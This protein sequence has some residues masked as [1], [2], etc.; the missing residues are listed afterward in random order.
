MKDVKTN[1]GR[2]L[3]LRGGVS[4]LA[5][6]L[7]GAHG[8]QAQT[9]AEPKAEEAPVLEEIVVVGVR[10]ALESAL[11]IKRNAGTVVDSITATDIGAFPDKSVSEALQRVPGITVSRLQSSDD[12]THPS[13]EGTSVLIRGLTQ[14]RTEF[15]GRD[16]F[17]ADSYRGLN[18]NDVSPELMA[19]VDSYK[20]Q[21]ADMIEGGIAG[22]V[23]LR[24]RLPF[25]SDGLAIAGNIKGSYGDRSKKWTGEYS[26]MISNVWETNAGKF[27]LLANL[28][29][30]HVVT[31]TESV[32]MDKIDTYC[33]AGAVDA[34]GKAI[35]GADGAVGCTRNPFGGTGWAYMPDGIR[36]SL[37][38]YDRTRRGTSLAGQYE[39]DDGSFQATVQYN[40]SKYHNAWLENAS[41]VI[42][43]GNAYGSS[44]FRVRDTSV[45]GPATGSPALK[46]GADGMLESGLL[47]QGHGSWRGS[48][49]SLQDAI[50]TGSAVPGKPFVN[51]CG[52]GAC[53]STTLQDGLYFQN[54]ARN[55]DHREGTKDLS[56]NVKW[57]V[58]DRLHTSFDVQR[59]TA[60]TTNDDILVATG[61]M[62]D[63]QYSVG[64]NGVPNVVMKPGSN[65]NYAPGGLSN[66]H[67]YWIPFIQA[68]LEDNDAK[69]TAFRGDA[70]YDLDAA[71]GW[72][73]SLKVGVRHADRKQTVRYSTF[74]W[75]PVAASWN[76]NGPGF[77]ADSTGGAYPAGCGNGQPF[78]GY[79]A[80]IWDSVNLGDDFFN[81]DVYPNG[82]LVYLSR[83]VLKDRDRLVKSLSGPNTNNPV[84]PGWV[85]ICDRPG[86]PSGSCFLPS[87]VMHVQEKTNA[88]Y[89]MLR[90]GGGDMTIFN[91]ITVDGNVG[92][93]IVETKINSQ[94]SVGFPTDT[95]LRSLQG[96]PCGST[97]PPGAV[98]NPAC[99]LTPAILAFANGA[100]TANDFKTDYTNVLPSFNVR[101]GLD[102]DQYIRFAASRAM[103]RP[104]FGLLR[105]FVSIQSPV[106]DTTAS[107]P[108]LV[109]NAA[110]QVTGYNFVFRAESGYAGL[111]PLKAD[112]FDLGYEY[113][114][115]KSGLFSVGGFYK[116][117][118][119][120]ISYGEFVREFTNGTSTQTVITRGPRNQKG[121]GEL[122]GFETSY[123]TFFDFLPDFWNGLGMQVNYTYVE[124]SGINNSNLVTQGALDAG[125]T[126]GF[127]AGLDVSGGRGAVIDS[128]KLAGI[129][130][131]TYN[132]VGLYEQGPI[133][134]RLAYN[135]RSR[136]LTNNL[137]CCIGLPVFQKAAGFLD[138]SI[139]YSV[140]ENLEIALEGTNLLD[141]KTIYQQQI[142]GDSAVT[143]GAKPVYRD[144]NWGKADRRFQVGARVKF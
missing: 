31:R 106:I 2:A 73:N 67:N 143:P 102:D 44:A 75:T 133:G 92:V 8:A 62:A 46:F 140:S 43:D 65:V 15:N 48:W 108:Y 14:V 110:G 141:T 126:G 74:N 72:L 33:S 52:N 24:T 84:S 20:N 3:W 11:D 142:F 97:L 81:G 55:F 98:V 100:G 103:A 112:Q 125:G 129:S 5:L 34:S 114:L 54:E 16:S 130:K 86:L 124:Q 132:I 35:I 93:R 50:N 96:T 13:G 91:G 139:R 18:F 36:Y 39:N 113:Y 22:T 82:D 60:S 118:R 109:K 53:S 134:L 131:H 28:A 49:D 99:S 95:A 104:D 144:A 29:R 77:N 7:V 41:H 25:D 78:K 116:K 123:Q 122:Y 42:L 83:E 121:G 32:I 135:W 101:F 19:G 63:M 107:S 23:N 10:A 9:A 12:S 94:G 128:H 115:G 88:G 30:S 80:G 59:I 45:I 69:E 6:A 138:G 89:A 70:T 127:G 117:L 71:D 105:N 61:S 137:D 58:N 85:P 4:L 120:S 90:F 136:F 51:Y 26:G 38:D 56:F 119:N 87:E 1:H 40:H 21:T 111:K 47:T 66:P 79:G 17:S 76:C 68:H 64:K 27:G 37:V 57:D